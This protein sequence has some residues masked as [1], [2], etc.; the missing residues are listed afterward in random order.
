MFVCVCGRPAQCKDPGCSPPAIPGILRWGWNWQLGWGWG[1]EM[2]HP[3]M[4]LK[5]HSPNMSKCQTQTGDWTKLT[6]KPAAQVDLKTQRHQGAISDRPA[7]SVTSVV[8]FGGSLESWKIHNMSC[9]YPEHL[10]SKFT[11]CSLPYLAM[12]TIVSAWMSD[13]MLV[14]RA[15]SGRLALFD[16]RS[17]KR[18]HVVENAAV[19]SPVIAHCGLRPTVDQIEEHVSLFFELA[20]PKGK[21]R[22]TR[23]LVASISK[24]LQIIWHNFISLYYII[25]SSI[26]GINGP[27]S[28]HWGAETRTAAWVIRRLISLFGRASKRGHYPGKRL[29]VRSLWRLTFRC[30]TLPE[31]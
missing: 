24:N 9:H 2:G 20:R 8:W 31:T 16:G 25:L 28:C 29:C 1:N 30:L 23:T 21:R 13:D 18:R 19:I 17:L 5:F 10:V 15:A 27:V 4:M 12:S 22:A 26:N 3:H 11:G 6:K 7:P 14:A